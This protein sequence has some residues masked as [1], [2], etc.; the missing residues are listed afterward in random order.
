MAINMGK[1]GIFRRIK[2][3]STLYRRTY[4]TNNDGKTG[5]VLGAYT[6]VDRDLHLT[7]ASEAFNAKSNGKLLENM[8]L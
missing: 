2:M 1:M 7:P 4:S 5:L 3:F 8:K 6:S